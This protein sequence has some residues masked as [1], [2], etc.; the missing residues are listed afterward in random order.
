MSETNWIS[1]KD[2]HQLTGYDANY[3]REL[4]RTGRIRSQKFGWATQIDREDLQRYKH[5]QD[6][7]R[8]EGER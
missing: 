8:Q 3:I 2:A 4:A 5:E 7:K 1:V 6:L